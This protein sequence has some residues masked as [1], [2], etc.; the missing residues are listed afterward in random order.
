M[1]SPFRHHEGEAGGKDAEHEMDSA[2]QSLDDHV[3]DRLESDDDGETE[4]VVNACEKDC[5]LHCCKPNHESPNQPTSS[6][7]PIK[8]KKG[9]W[10]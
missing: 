6:T 2:S 5:C 1:I 7:I 8:T 10:R 4:S 3:P 9:L